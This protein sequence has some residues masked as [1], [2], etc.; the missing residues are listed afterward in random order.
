[1]VKYKEPSLDRTFAALADPTRRALLAMV[2]ANSPET[3]GIPAATV[4]LRLVR[5]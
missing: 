5:R 2:P 3:A 1:M 4:P